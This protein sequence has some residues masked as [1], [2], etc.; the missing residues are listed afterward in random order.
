MGNEH[1]NIICM[2]DNG[3]QSS[4]IIETNEK[5]TSLRFSVYVVQ[6]MDPNDKASVSVTFN[7]EL[8]PYYVL[9]AIPNINKYKNIELDISKVKR[10]E[11]SF[12]NGMGSTEERTSAILIESLSLM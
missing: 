10:V 12:G 11:I 1:K 3:D 8:E 7:D 6:G 5:Y 2:K 4:I 9:S